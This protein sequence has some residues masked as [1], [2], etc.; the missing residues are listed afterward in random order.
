V[1]YLELVPFILSKYLKFD[2]DNLKRKSVGMEQGVSSTSKEYQL[3]LQH[4]IPKEVLE[5]EVDEM[6]YEEPNLENNHKH[7][8]DPSIDSMKY[9]NEHP[10]ESSLDL[11][12]LQE[13]E[14]DLQ[15]NDKTNLIEN[16]VSY[17]N[18]Q[19]ENQCDDSNQ[20]SSTSVDFPIMKMSVIWGVTIVNLLI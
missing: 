11:S 15:P 6:D 8:L 2:I 4:C 19:L 5:S 9:L 14:V 7:S 1:K 10:F 12:I 13:D 20:L 16:E 17:M 3:S 18:E